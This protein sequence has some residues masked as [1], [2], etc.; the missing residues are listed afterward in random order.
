LGIIV[1]ADLHPAIP[2][3][4]ILKAGMAV[5]SLAIA[6]LFSGL[7]VLLA[8]RRRGAYYPAIGILL[9]SALLNVFDD[10]GAADLVF[11][12]LNIIPIILLVK[13]KAWFLRASSQ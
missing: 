3:Q 1:A 10:F 4:P 5:V 9:A 12:V 6:V 2:D 8:R 11:L 7:V 13:D